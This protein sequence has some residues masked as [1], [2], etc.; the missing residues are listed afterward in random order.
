MWRDREK[1]RGK[2]ACI[3]AERA[4]VHLPV[5][6]VGC[7]WNRD[8]DAQGTNIL[9]SLFLQVLSAGGVIAEE[10]SSLQSSGSPCGLIAEQIL[11]SLENG[12][13]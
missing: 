13:P 5:P 11:L 3:S 2:E 6:E 1:K 4:Y 9:L 7:D 8:D 12:E 10:E